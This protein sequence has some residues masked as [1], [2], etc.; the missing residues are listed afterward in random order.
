MNHHSGNFNQSFNRYNPHQNFP[1][2]TNA[3][4]FSPNPYAIDE[5]DKVRFILDLFY[6][7]I[8]LN[9]IELSQNIRWMLVT[10]TIKT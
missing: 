4:L 6:Y 10:E 3:N 2:I 7:R 9:T 8:R 5:S 1:S